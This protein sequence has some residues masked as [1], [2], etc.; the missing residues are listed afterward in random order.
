ML[1]LQDQQQPFSGNPTV[2]ITSIPNPN[3]STSEQNSAAAYSQHQLIFVK[4]TGTFSTGP[5]TCQINLSNTGIS[6]MQ[7]TTVK[8]LRSSGKCITAITVPRHVVI[9]ISK[10][11]CGCNNKQTYRGKRSGRFIFSELS[12]DH[13]NTRLKSLMLHDD[14]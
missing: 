12:T 1:S 10:S 3:P 6:W 11:A 8:C 5:E 13:K 4:Y 2:T 7:I 9:S 14:D